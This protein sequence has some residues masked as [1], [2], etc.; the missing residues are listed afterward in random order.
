M[1]LSMV[2]A[3]RGS[4]VSRVQQNGRLKGV[5]GQLTASTRAIS[6]IGV[7]RRSLFYVISMGA[8]DLVPAK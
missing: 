6:T 5:H 8:F 3:A 7:K 4:M 1:T 2:H